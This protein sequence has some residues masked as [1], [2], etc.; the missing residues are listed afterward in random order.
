MPAV[1][2]QFSAKTTADEVV[3]ALDLNGRCVLVTGANSGIGLET[4]RVLASAGARV[5]VGARSIERSEAAIAQIRARHT[6]AD[7][8]PFVADLGSVNDCLDA[9]QALNEPALHG[10]V[11]NAGL[12]A[13]KY[14]QT[15]DGFERTVGVCHFGHAA[16]FR[17]L[18]D[19]LE[20]GAPSRVVMVSSESHHGEKNLDPEHLSLKSDEYSMIAAYSR[21]KLCNVLFANELNRR[22][23]DQGIQGFS[24]HPGTLIA[25]SIGR[26]SW[27]AWFALLLYRPWAKSLAQGAATQVF[28]TV[29]PSL[30]EHGGAYLN[31]TAIGRVSRAGK[32]VDLAR[33]LWDATERTLDE[34]T[35]Q[36]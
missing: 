32:D 29:H 12:V 15:T 22:F 17:G 13:P 36:S 4:A 35:V 33:R 9:A 7:V 25:T 14:G 10:F 21:A 26:E 20:A 23:R 11:A 34:L 24:L 5:Y 6:S 18:R 2:P 28:A 19:K 3:Q 31:D 1:E 27:L 16:L 30:N 8:R